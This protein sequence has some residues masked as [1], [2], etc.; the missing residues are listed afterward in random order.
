M[1]D[2][3]AQG[4]PMRTDRT[5]VVPV[6]VEVAEALLESDAA[7]R[8]RFGPDVA[9]GY[10]AFPEALPAT[11]D[12]L[13]CGMPPQWFSYLVIDPVEDLVVG[14][15][16]FT[17]PPVDGAVE[18]GYSVAPAHRGRGHATA[19]ARLWLD[20]AAREGV[21]LVRAHTLAEEGPS[22]TVLRRLGFERVA[23]IDDAEDGP[24]WRWERAPGPTT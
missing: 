10:L 23:E 17:G 18:I 21:S 15:G 8:E 7:F 6:T 20:L 13:R 1:T 5:E 19:A 2:V 11:L 14:M 3:R 4:H 16:G 12:A 22:T 9:T 24:V